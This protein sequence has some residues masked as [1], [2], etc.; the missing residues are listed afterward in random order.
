[1]REFLARNS[2]TVLEH[3]PYSP[4]LAPCNFFLFPKWKLVLRGAALGDVTIKSEMTSL[5]KGLKERKSKG[6]CSNGNG[7]GTNVLC[8][9]GSIV[10]GTTLTYPKICK[11]KFL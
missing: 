1:V 10:K 8:L 3:P 11:I 2:I 7:G 5:L 6:A 9:M 4:D